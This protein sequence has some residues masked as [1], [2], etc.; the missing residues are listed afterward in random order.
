MN[1]NEK[2][3][4]LFEI[5]GDLLFMSHHE[6][7]K[8]YLR[9]NFLLCH[10]ATIWMKWMEIQ[11]VASERLKYFIKKERELI[12]EKCP[13]YW[14]VAQAISIDLK[15]SIELKSEWFESR[16]KKTLF[17]LR[18]LESEMYKREITDILPY[19]KMFQEAKDMYC[20]NCKWF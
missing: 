15:K 6:L 11:D 12:G 14:L 5:K 20:P 13:V 18:V 3:K 9:I 2:T 7:C 10:A 16:C 17:K 1:L 4:F 19:V 8:E